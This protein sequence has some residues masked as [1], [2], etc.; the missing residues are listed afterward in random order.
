MAGAALTCVFAH[1]RCLRA[2]CPPDCARSRVS[3]HETARPLGGPFCVSGQVDVRLGGDPRDEREQEEPEEHAEGDLADP[4]P[5]LPSLRPQFG[6]DV[7][8]Q[9]GHGRMRLVTGPRP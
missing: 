7:G 5:P 4:G 8:G 6:T 2:L 1:I 3:K 9:I